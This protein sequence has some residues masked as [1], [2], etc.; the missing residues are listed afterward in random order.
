MKVKSNPFAD[1]CATTKISSLG[2]SVTTY[3]YGRKLAYKM[4]VDRKLLFKGTDFKP[5]PLYCID[6]IQASVDLLSFLS[7]G[8]WDTDLSYF[9]DYN[10]RQIE[11]ANDRIGDIMITTRE[12]LSG[13]L[14]D[15][16]DPKSEF[17]P[18]A[19]KEFKHIIH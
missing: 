12:T 6:N 18:D 7:V 5:S 4:Y 19:I 9:E 11:W 14:S 17:Q 2:V 8:L 16:G 13:L 1:K 10:Q 15:Y 3:Y